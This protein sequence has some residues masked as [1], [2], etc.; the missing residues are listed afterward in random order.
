MCDCDVVGFVERNL[1]PIMM[2]T[3]DIAHDKIITKNGAI[4]YGWSQ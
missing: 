3:P 4:R 2:I 1:P